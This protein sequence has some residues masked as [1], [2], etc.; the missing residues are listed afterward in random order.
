VE[1]LRDCQQSEESLVKVVERAFDHLPA[2]RDGVREHLQ[3]AM[4]HVRTLLRE[5]DDVGRSLALELLGSTIQTLGDL[6]SSSRQSSP[7]PQEE[8]RR[9]VQGHQPNGLQ[10]SPSGE[11]RLARVESDRLTSRESEILALIAAGRTSAEIA[12]ELTISVRT[13]GRHITN[14]YRKIGAKRRAD[15]AAYALQQGL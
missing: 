12:S 2:E 9:L 15:A 14:I 6:G 10:E 5:G 3:S 4:Q 1:T 7:E 13:V 11:P 8:I